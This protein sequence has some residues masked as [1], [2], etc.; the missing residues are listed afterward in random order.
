MHFPTMSTVPKP[1]VAVIQ[2]PSAVEGTP[3]VLLAY[4]VILCAAILPYLTTLSY[5]FVY[6]DD[7]QV[8]G[9]PALKAWHM[10]PGYFVHP[11][12]GFTV[13]YY[14]PLFFLW[15]QVNHYLWGPRPWGWH[16]GSVLLHAA[17]SL[18]VLAV[19]RRYITDIKWAA[20]GALIFAVHPAHVETVA[21]I[22]GS[23]DSLMSIGLLGSLYPWMK[24]R[25]DYSFWKQGFSLICAGLAILAKE[26]AVL[27]PAI[28]FLHAIIGIPHVEGAPKELGHRLAIALRQTVPYLS[29]AAAC[30]LLRAWV[31]RGFPATQQSIS[32][33][34]GLLTVP[35]LLLFYLKHLIWPSRLS[36]NY[37]L[38]VVTSVHGWSFWVPLA[39]LGIAVMAG[40]FWL[41][42]NPEMRAL[43][44]AVWFLLPLLPVLYLP[45]F[46]EDDFVHDR[47]LYLPVISLSIT[48]AL[49]AEY[50]GKP[51]MRKKLG[52]VPLVILGSAVLSLSLAT[53]VQ[54]RPW[55]SNLSLYRNAVQIAPNNMLAKNNLAREYAFEGHYQEAAEMFREILDVRP[56]MWLANYNYGFVNYRLGNLALA[57]RYLVQAIRINSSD[58]DQHI[59]LG[60]TYLK[61]GRLGEA[62]QQVRLGIARKTDG[63]GYH[64]ALAIILLAQGNPAA[65]REEL[66]QEL[67]YHPENAP[68]VSRVQATSPQLNTYIR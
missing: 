30:L 28:I 52:I 50:F 44:A 27:L 42:R 48:A 39:L 15:L 43:A 47:Y 61:Q 31:L 54:S 68:A 51:E 64:L 2:P 65:G 19:L 26:T 25:E 14:R 33:T 41:L 7:V 34:D 8:A 35:T 58:A 63:S 13:R 3:P 32:L 6:D 55:K 21:W 10:L 1:P 36:L 29:V 12:P 56:T 59:C 37:D 60:T 23:T 38:A 16:L 20:L 5:G 4:F 17:A 45:L 24:S 66:Q 18:L 62:E 49:L 67:K 9:M 57:E 11:I 53:V 22:S 46:Q 40:C